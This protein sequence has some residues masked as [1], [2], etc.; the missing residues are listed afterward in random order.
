MVNTAAWKD[1][2]EKRCCLASARDFYAQAF[3][4]AEAA[5][6]V[7]N[8]AGLN[9]ATIAFLLGPNGDR[10]R[11]TAIVQQCA[12]EAVRRTA[13]GSTFWD[14]AGVPDALLLGALWEETLLTQSDA[15]QRAYLDLLEGG[16]IP[17][18]FDSVLAQ[19]E[20]LLVELASDPMGTASRDAL[21]KLRDNLLQAGWPRA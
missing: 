8:Y 3:E 7:D 19:M 13:S 4:R 6:S 5:G 9:A 16:G 20:T 12:D 18:A 17:R 1:G 14:R 11:W 15:I 21:T 2:P 10:A